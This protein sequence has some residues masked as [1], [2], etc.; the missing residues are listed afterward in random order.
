MIRGAPITVPVG[1]A[2][3]GRGF[4][5]LGEPIDDKGPVR[6]QEY[7]PI[8]QPGL[9]DFDLSRLLLEGGRGLMDRRYS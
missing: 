4:N 5:V 8:H 3:L 7:R 2:T 1:E 6:A 9:E